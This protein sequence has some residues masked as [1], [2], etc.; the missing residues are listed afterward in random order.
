MTR[1]AVPPPV[2]IAIITAIL[3]PPL[4]AC[5]TI[6]MVTVPIPAIKYSLTSLPLGLDTGLLVVMMTVVVIGMTC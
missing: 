5:K 1:N 3:K 4:S 2:A 6:T